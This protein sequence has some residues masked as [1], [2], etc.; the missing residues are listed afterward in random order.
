MLV[1]P[2]QQ[3][4]ELL[5]RNPDVG[6]SARIL[7][8][9]ERAD[10]EHYEAAIQ[11][12]L[13]TWD[14]RITG[15]KPWEVV[16]LSNE[17]DGMTV[18]DLS[19]LMFVPD[20]LDDPLAA[21]AVAAIEAEQAETAAT[22]AAGDRQA[23]RLSAMADSVLLSRGIDPASTHPDTWALAAKIAGKIIDKEDCD[24]AR[25]RSLELSR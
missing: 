22:L 23:D 18:I 10:G 1:R 12:A 15:M 24:A 14:P 3:G 25:R 5:S 17:D 21:E 9:Y 4:E 2:D 6:V 11:H 8:G 20:P 19:T 16:G 7:E 13:I